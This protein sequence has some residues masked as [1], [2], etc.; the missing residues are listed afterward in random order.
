[1]IGL[2][3]LDIALRVGAVSR[4]PVLFQLA[5]LPPAVRALNQ[6][7]DNVEL[8]TLPDEFAK[9]DRAFA[10]ENGFRGVIDL[11]DFAF[12]P[13]F[14]CAP[15]IDFFLR[16]LGVDPGRIPAAER[17]NAW[18][19]PRVA[20]EAPDFPPGYILV[21]PRASA[22]LRHMPEAI[23]T[24][25]VRRAAAI[26]T[27]VTQGDAPLGVSGDVVHAPPCLS[28]PALCGL[29]ANARCII[30]TDT[31]MVHLAD[32]FSVPCL[33]FFPTHHPQWR[34]RDYPHCTA[35]ALRGTLPPG[36]E[37]A[38]HRDDEARAA[39]SWFPDGDD[40]GWLDSA[41]APVLAR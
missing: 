18:L 9:P 17:R 2:Q 41:L 33:A 31:G 40:L 35:V 13:D 37:F 7:F 21:C 14:Q 23:H 32:A 29:V 38:R 5:S 24:H 26:A 25:V 10:N 39:A 16:R 20:P 22:P 3:A 4:W 36:I 15:M 19:A 28:L 34:V 30:S 8:R 12:A 27:V 11:R 1:M 6:L